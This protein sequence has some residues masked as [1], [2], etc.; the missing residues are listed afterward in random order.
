MARSTLWTNYKILL[1]FYYS[2]SLCL[3]GVYTGITR[4][5]NEKQSTPI[6]VQ[7]VTVAES[8]RLS[9]A[10]VVCLSMCTLYH[11]CGVFWTSQ[12]LTFRG[13]EGG[14]CWFLLMV[15]VSHIQL[16]LF[17]NI[18]QIQNKSS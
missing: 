12:K 7:T 14:A 8:K 18:E 5:G 13:G 17:C 1:S 9:R 10:N 2:T 6:G 4:T 11:H 16:D 15:L 3:G